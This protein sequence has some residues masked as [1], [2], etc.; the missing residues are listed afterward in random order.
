MGPAEKI[1]IIQGFHCDFY[2]LHRMY[3]KKKIEKRFHMQVNKSQNQDLI[4]KG[5]LRHS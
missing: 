2:A 5:F 4:L 3:G 1:I